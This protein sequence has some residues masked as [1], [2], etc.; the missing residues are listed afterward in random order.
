MRHHETVMALVTTATLVRQPDVVGDL[1]P[2]ARVVFI[3]I[4]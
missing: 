1:Y 4:P 3:P 2:L